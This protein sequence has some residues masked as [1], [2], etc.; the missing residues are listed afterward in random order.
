MRAKKHVFATWRFTTHGCV[1]P[2]MTLSPLTSPPVTIAEP[3]ASHRRADPT[4]K[5][6]ESSHD[7]TEWSVPNGLSAGVAPVHDRRPATLASDH[8]PSLTKLE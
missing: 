6:D 8:R 1:E 4:G 2:T 5:H 7:C 3:S